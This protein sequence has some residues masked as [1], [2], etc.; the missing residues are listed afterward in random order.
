MTPKVTQPPP[1]AAE[2][3]AEIIATAITQIAESM[4]VLNNTRLTRKALVALIHDHSKVPKR[5]IEIV[6]NNLTALETVWLKPRV[7]KK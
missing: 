4:R 7:A 6:L 1:P 5:T 3:P 2:I